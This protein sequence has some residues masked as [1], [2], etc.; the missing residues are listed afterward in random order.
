MRGAKVGA[1]DEA[2]RPLPEAERPA[3]AKSGAESRADPKIETSGKRPKSIP[4]TV[5]ATG[6]LDFYVFFLDRMRDIT[7]DC[8]MKTDEIASRLELQKAQVSVWLKRGL[9]DGRIEKVAKPVRYRS[10]EN[11]ERQASLF[12][13]NG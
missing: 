10:T 7:A 4:E 6:T 8:P 1:A 5:D 11:A 9:S 13:E 2:G 3:T 12:A